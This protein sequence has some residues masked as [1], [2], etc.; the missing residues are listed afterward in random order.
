MRIFSFIMPDNFSCL[1]CRSTG[2][3]NLQVDA[4]RGCAALRAPED[5]AVR[6]ANKPLHKVNK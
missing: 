6:S 1:T 4:R 3:V 5:D 2:L